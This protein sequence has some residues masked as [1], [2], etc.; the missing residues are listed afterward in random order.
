MNTNVFLP[1]NLNHF[2]NA[3]TKS[4]L[5]QKASEVIKNDYNKLLLEL[6]KAKSDLE[7]AM[8]N[9]NYVSSP[10]ETDIYIYQIKNS[11]TQYENILSQLQCILDRF[12]NLID[13]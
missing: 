13:D 9:F 2:V 4:R 3:K 7:C 12:E 11:Q 10:K 5:E 8:I 1:S 6:N